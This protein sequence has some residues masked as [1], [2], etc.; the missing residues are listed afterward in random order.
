MNTPDDRSTTLG[1]PLPQTEVKIVD[2]TTGET[3]AP[4]VVGEL[5]TRG[6]HVMTG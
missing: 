5:C 6:Y 3:V 1:R 2:V 4:D